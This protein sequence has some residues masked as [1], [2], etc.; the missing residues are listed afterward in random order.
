MNVSRWISLSIAIIYIFFLVLLPFLSGE[1]KETSTAEIF[2]GIFGLA[3]WLAICLGCIWFGDDLGE[4][5]VG[6]KFGLVSSKSPG[7][8]I[9]LMGWVLLVIPVIVAFIL[10]FSSG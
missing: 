1:Y 4:G 3:I 7:W 9:E 10:A 5:M 2:E 8:A 6:A